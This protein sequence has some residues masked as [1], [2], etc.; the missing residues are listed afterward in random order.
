M[1]H[2]RQT[3]VS[4]LFIDIII[5]GVFKKVVQ[6]FILHVTTKGLSSCHKLSDYLVE[7]IELMC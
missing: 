1:K 3:F 6:C 4:N 7:H 5:D 2:L